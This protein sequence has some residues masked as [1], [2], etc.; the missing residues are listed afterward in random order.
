MVQSLEV[1]N[2]LRRFCEVNRYRFNLRRSDFVP[3]DLVR[4]RK[5]SR[6]QQLSSAEHLASPMKKAISLTPTRASFLT[7]VGSLSLGS[8]RSRCRASR[9]AHLTRR[10]NARFQ[11]IQ[12][13]EASL[14]HLLGGT[15]ASF[16]LARI[17]EVA[18][19]GCRRQ[20]HGIRLRT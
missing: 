16:E 20:D 11:F 3:V 10:F 8:C 17:Q 7:P 14:T 5:K 15:S 9:A 18:N 19:F 12:S 13:G 6:C 4:Y 2:L 1:S